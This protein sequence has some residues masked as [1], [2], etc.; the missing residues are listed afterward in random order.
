MPSPILAFGI[1]NLPM[2]GWLAAAA[3]PIL[4][5]LWS[6]RKYRETTWA[7]MEYLLAALER[8]ARRIQLE[9]W[10]LLA[11]RTLVIV[12]VVLAAAEPYLERAGLMSAAG[13]QTHRVLVLDGSYSMA[14]Q[15]TDKSRF[16][17]AK[18]LAARI[19]EE[20][21]QGDAFTLVLLAAPPR[22]VVGTPALDKRDVLQEIDSLQLVHTTLDLPATVP[23]LEELIERAE[24]DNPRLQ[25]H[26]VYFLTDLGRAGW[27]PRLSP[28]A[29]AE[30]RRRSQELSQAAVFVVFDVG[31]ASADNVAVTELR[32]LDP[33]ATIGQNLRFEAVLK[34]F[35][36]ST[37]SRQPVDLLVD[38]RRVARQTME[39][40]SGDEK[41]T[42]MTYLLETPG[43]HVVEARTEG[44]SL[45]VDN[46]RWLALRV[47]P[48]LRVLCIDGRP[49]G[50]PL[51][52]ASA[53]LARALAPPTDRAPQS[54]VQVEVAPESALVE[55]DLSRYDAI[56]FCNVAQFTAGEARVLD[57]YLAQ[58]GGLVF[59]LGDNVLAERY[60]RQLGPGTEGSGLLPARLEEVVQ[61]LETRLDPRG[62]RH[63]I[64]E[65]FRG[66]DRAGLLTT[67]VEQYFKLSIPQPSKARVALALG[68]G[69]PL[70][71]E[72]PVRRGR[73]VL[74]ATSADR[75]WTPMPIWPS[76]VPL[77]Q[78][79]LAYC[80]GAQIQQRNVAVGAPLEGTLP[81]TADTALSI[82]GPDGRSRP[83]RLD[84]EGDY[85]TFSYPDTWTSGVYTA[86]FGAADNRGQSFAANVDTAES[87]LA[88]LG[89]DELRN[90]VWPGM[91]FHY[92]TT[93]QDLDGT[94]TATVVQTSRLHV[95][96]LYVLFGL[97]LA[98]TLMAWRFGHHAP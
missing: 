65:A 40:P 61:G 52:G 49:S 89:A 79:I 12:L 39:L 67:P 76:Y 43:E 74:V 60:N 9:Q 92:R 21:P 44:D 15:P 50:E 42:T 7:A 81:A 8:Q 32:T 80:M 37:R 46:H 86:Q 73:V 51:L 87:D 33:V 16:D 98:E 71:V 68:N 56:F 69:D 45:E 13:G 94:S 58:G 28:A 29:M 10:L 82:K 70:V 36:R 91:D 47:R 5:H 27:M 95:T 2:L 54:P 23:L 53:Y 1:A 97:L 3:A 88:P 83:V 96:L 14:Y 85:S 4:I 75:S 62:Y 22:V 24:H 77:V 57:G 38:G 25:Q 66:S 78:E 26:E 48:S 35:G 34:N 30:F 55:Q 6:R 17:R 41:S 93:W 90:E 72:Q 11:V 18:E 84:R 59:F 20:S 31:Q 63:P 19:V 64:V